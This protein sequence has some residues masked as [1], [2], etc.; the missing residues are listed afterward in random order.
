MEPLRSLSVNPFG[1]QW[2][3]RPKDPVR[4]QEELQAQMEQNSE[5]WYVGKKQGKLAQKVS[6]VE[7]VGCKRLPV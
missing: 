3:T 6:G 4:K 1:S 2:K 7:F 5:K